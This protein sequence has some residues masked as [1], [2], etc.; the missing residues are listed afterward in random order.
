MWN[1]I[2]KKIR[3]APDMQ[4]IVVISTVIILSVVLTKIF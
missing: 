4:F 2:V 3:T 1:K